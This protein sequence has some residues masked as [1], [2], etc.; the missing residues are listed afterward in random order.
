MV[1]I[2]TTGVDEAN[3]SSA[4]FSGS[5]AFRLLPSAVRRNIGE[6]AL[7]IAELKREMHG[8]TEP[9]VAS[10]CGACLGACC[11]SG[12]YHF[13]VPDLLIHLALNEPVPAPSFTGG[14]CPYLGTDGCSMR[15]L[16]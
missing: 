13:T 11:R 10:A 15:P 2:S 8:V 5:E 6:T 1:F 16:L 4:G 7:E 12:K 14:K 3:W 9:A